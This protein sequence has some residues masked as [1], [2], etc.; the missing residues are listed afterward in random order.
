MVSASHS[1][2][3]CN[4]VFVLHAVNP[5]LWRSDLNRA[6][7]YAPV[8]CG[9]LTDQRFP[10]WKCSNGGFWGLLALCWER[11]DMVYLL[12]WD[13][14]KI[15]YLPS[16]LCSYWPKSASLNTKSTRKSCKVGWMKSR[17]TRTVLCCWALCTLV[18]NFTG[19]Y[20]SYRFM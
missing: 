5:A 13:C 20:L 11:R 8:W 6:N 14:D 1:K 19:R 12:L 7:K 10:C 16:Y 9:A 15:I 4:F 3:F 2:I 18:Q 17:P